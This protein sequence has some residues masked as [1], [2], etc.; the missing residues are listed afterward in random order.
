MPQGS[1]LIFELDYSVI[2]RLANEALDAMSPEQLG[3]RGYVD[4]VLAFARSDGSEDP[5]EHRQMMIEL[6][7]AQVDTALAEAHL[8]LIQA[9]FDPKAYR[10]NYDQK[11]DTDPR[12]NEYITAET[13]EGRRK[14]GVCGLGGYGDEDDEN[15]HLG[16]SI[17]S[18]YVPLWIDWRDPY[19]GSSSSIKF[20]KE[21]LKMTE[22]AR[23]AFA[24]VI[25]EIKDAEVVVVGQWY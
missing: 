17:L 14:F 9:R 4:D 18:R 10:C 5:D 15:G 13:P 3:E 20:S 7:A 21:T 8:R 1:E 6:A 16:I 23:V 19:G 12:E 2:T 22:E 24:E 25:P 11:V